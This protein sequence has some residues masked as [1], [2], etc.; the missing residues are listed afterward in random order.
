MTQSQSNPVMEFL[1][2]RRSR[3]TAALRAPAPDAATIAH[4]L[5]AATRVPDHGRMEPWRFLIID[6]AAK[7]RL[8]ALIRER[9]EA[10]GVAAEKIE[11]SAK[12]WANAPLIVAVVS[13]PKPSE[14]VPP[15]E[16]LLSAGAVC[17]SLVNAALASGWGAAWVTG[18]AAFDREFMDTGL[19]LSAHE[20]IAGFVHLGSCD[21]PVSDRPRPD[22]AALTTWVRA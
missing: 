15:M 12:T 13:T 8:S 9:G 10:L 21:T 2:S 19:G 22:T 1:L 7:D 17:L 4:L 3:P 20:S 18:W 6:G 14:K 11:K 16:Q 5:T